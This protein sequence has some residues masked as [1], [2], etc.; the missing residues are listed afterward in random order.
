[1]SKCF[2]VLLLNINKLI[3]R[4]FR[5]L[6]DIEYSYIHIHEK[7][8]MDSF[9]F[10]NKSYSITI[11]YDWRCEYLDLT[12]KNDTKILFQT[13]YDCIVINYL[14]CGEKDFLC[15]LKNIY[16]L[17]RCS[18]SLSDEQFIKLA[19]FYVDCVMVFLNQQV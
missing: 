9:Q 7:R 10:Q 6:L 3:E 1:M 11:S 4:K 16:S 2:E 13:C 17:P 19:D 12:I 18:Y 8:F 15:L 14:D 5:F